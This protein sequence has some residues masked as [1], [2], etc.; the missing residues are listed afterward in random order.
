MALQLSHPKQESV[1]PLAFSWSRLK[2]PPDA[3][4]GAGVLAF[5]NIF[6]D[7]K[8]KVDLDMRNRK[9]RVFVGEKD[10][11]AGPVIDVTG[12][13]P[14]FFAGKTTPFRLAG[15]LLRRI[16]QEHENEFFEFMQN[17]EI[18]GIL[19]ALDTG[20]IS[21]GS[22]FSEEMWIIAL[23][24][25]GF[26]EARYV[27]ERPHMP[28]LPWLAGKAKVRGIQMV[29][30]MCDLSNKGTNP[31]ELTLPTADEISRPTQYIERMAGIPEIARVLWQK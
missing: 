28:R 20:R 6:P 7:T 12:L 2:I 17:L 16:F 21:K 19:Q 11:D 18:P 13:G 15:P 24:R 8:P 1:Q 26:Y 23:G 9:M 30:A 31:L 10:A 5:K 29:H 14:R 22:N 27:G 3:L 25:A 4:M